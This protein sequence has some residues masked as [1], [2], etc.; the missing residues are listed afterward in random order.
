MDNIR[1]KQKE[2]K[3]YELPGTLRLLSKSNPI[4]GDGRKE[5]SRTQ[6][7]HYDFGYLPE[8]HFRKPG[9]EGDHMYSSLK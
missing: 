3:L 8:D 4:T 9:K 2:Q 7:R 5:I 1:V 6:K